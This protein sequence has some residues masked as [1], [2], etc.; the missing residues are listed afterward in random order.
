MMRLL[1]D[2]LVKIE[3]QQSSLVVARGKK[4]STLYV[5]HAK[6]HIREINVVQKMQALIY[7]T[8]GLVTST[9]KRLKGKFW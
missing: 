5:M 4:T 6:L 8:K 7:G 3:A 9:R 2:V 1:L